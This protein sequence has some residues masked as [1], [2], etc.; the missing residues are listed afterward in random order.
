MIG[1]G[2]LVVVCEVATGT[3]SWCISVV[4]VLVA[5]RTGKTNMGTGQHIIGVVRA[6]CSRAPSGV[7]SMAGST[8]GSESQGHMRRIGCLVIVVYMATCAYIWNICVIV[9][10]MAGCT[11]YRS[12]CTGQSVIGIV[13]PKTCGSPARIRCMTASTI[14]R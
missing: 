10:S 1:I 2:G 3:I 12:V 14:R 4:A 5:G 7:S 6:K 8:I 9:A 13:Y 11:D